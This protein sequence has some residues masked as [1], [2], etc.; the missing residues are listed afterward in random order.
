MRNTWLDVYRAMPDDEKEIYFD[1]ILDGNQRT[2]VFEYSKFKH[3]LRLIASSVEELQIE[4]CDEICIPEEVA[5][6]FG[7][8]CVRV[9]ESLL[10]EGYIDREVYDAVMQ[11]DKYLQILS[12]ECIDDNWTLDSMNKDDRWVESREMAKNILKVL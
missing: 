11:I 5:L 9:S 2:I 7:E 3:A 6:I 8:E 4:F 1:Y 12:V 10:K